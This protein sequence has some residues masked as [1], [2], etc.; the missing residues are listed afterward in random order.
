MSAI[1]NKLI[2]QLDFFLVEV[3]EMT[4]DVENVLRISV[5]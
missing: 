4:R 1:K 3:G 5:S 2:I